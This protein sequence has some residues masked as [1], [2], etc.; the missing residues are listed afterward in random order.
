MRGEVMRLFRRKKYLIHK[1]LQ[2]KYAILTIASLLLYT[3]LILSAIFMPP[4]VVFFS[5][6]L[7]LSVRAEAASAFVLLNDYIW[8]GIGFVIILFG[9]ISILVTHKIAGPIYVLTRTIREITSGDLKARITLRRGDDL[10]ELENVVNQ[11][12]E[13][14]ESAFIALDKRIGALSLLAREA[15]QGHASASMSQ[16]AAG[17]EDM[18]KILEGYKFGVKPND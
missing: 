2:L 1:K 17:I 12:A 11:M 3:L 6:H 13:K 15:A 10:V 5:T 16:M 18:K 7:P 8:P 9:A 4:A 14:I